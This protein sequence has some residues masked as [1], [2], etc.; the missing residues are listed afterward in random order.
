[1]VTLCTHNLICKT[2]LGFPVVAGHGEAV[3]EELLAD[4]ELE[5]GHPQPPLHFL[6]GIRGKFSTR[7]FLPLAELS[8]SIHDN[9]CASS[10]SDIE[11]T[12]RN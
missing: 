4:D 5:V 8:M 1:M 10:S 7:D 11:A 6:E 2:H 3:G 9:C 12:V